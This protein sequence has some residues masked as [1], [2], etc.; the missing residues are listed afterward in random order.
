M[1]QGVSN[2][3]AK[4]KASF[5]V[6]AFSGLE[7]VPT[8]WRPVPAG[9]EDEA[10]RNPFLELQEDAPVFAESEPIAVE[11]PGKRGRRGSK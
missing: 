4:A 7:F 2:V 10:R 1:P 9:L 6:R 8:E 11:P 3:L 5:T